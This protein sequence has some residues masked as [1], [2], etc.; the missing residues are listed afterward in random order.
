MKQNSR[1]R[2]LYNYRKRRV[3]V[4]CRKAEKEIKGERRRVKGEKGY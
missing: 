3:R 2:Q 1:K 4:Y